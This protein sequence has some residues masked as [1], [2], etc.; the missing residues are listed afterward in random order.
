MNK[1]I[2][3]IVVGIG[4]AL[5]LSVFVFNYF[6]GTGMSAEMA[7]SNSEELFKIIRDSVNQHLS[8]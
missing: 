8:S 3:L 6:S 2:I 7:P 1:K 4:L 5:V